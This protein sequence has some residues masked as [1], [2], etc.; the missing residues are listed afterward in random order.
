MWFSWLNDCWLLQISMEWTKKY[1][2]FFNVWVNISFQRML[3]PEMRQVTKEI[4]HFWLTERLLASQGQIFHV[5]KQ[6][7]MQVCRKRNHVNSG[8]AQWTLAQKTAVIRGMMNDTRPA[9]LPS[10]LPS[11][12]ILLGRSTVLGSRQ[13]KDRRL[14]L[15]FY[16][17]QKKERERETWNFISQVVEF[18]INSKTSS[19]TNKRTYRS[20]RMDDPPGYRRSD[21]F[22]YGST[23]LYGPGPGPPRFVDASRSHTLDTPHSVGLLWTR[24][25]LIA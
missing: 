14:H 19:V 23:A 2:V 16:T 11:S 21:F 24:D 8:S 1:A 17:K 7:N 20:T 22:F 25:Q 13:H 15:F 12:I 5:D 9:A 10:L 4:C 3:L 6:G 18:N